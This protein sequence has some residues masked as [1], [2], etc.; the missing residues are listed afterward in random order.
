[1]NDEDW[2]KRRRRGPRG[3]CATLVVFLGLVLVWAVG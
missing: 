1:M 2:L 3:G